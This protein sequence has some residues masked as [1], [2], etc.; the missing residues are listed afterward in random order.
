M[1]IPNEFQ[2][3]HNLCVYM[4]DVILD[5]LNSGYSNKM[6]MHKF[7]LTLDEVESLK[8]VEQ[9]DI[10][11][12]FEENN[13]P[14]ERSLTIRT[15]ILPHL[16]SDM[17]NFLYE[18]I[19][20]AE[21][22]KMSLAYTLLR[23][24][25]QEHL[26]LLEAMAV[27]EDFFVE[28][29]SEDPLY[30][31]PKNGGGVLGHTKRIH[32]IL[33]KNGL[34]HLIDCKYIAKLR[35]DKSDFDSFDR[36]CNQATHLF[37]EH[38][39]IKTEKQNINLIFSDDKDIY[40]QQRYFYTRMPYLL[41]YAYLV[42]EIVASKIAPAKENYINAINKKIAIQFLI[43]YSQMD[44]NYI[45]EPMV[46]VIKIFLLLLDIKISDPADVDSILHQLILMLDKD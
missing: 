41:Y 2:A 15:V 37:T 33:D 6:F 12:W 4:A 34:S 39:S 29:F 22:G 8:K 20:L 30:F 43:A 17:L 23:K 24:P 9:K 10:L 35:Y 44:G 40:T 46:R 38:K 32:K 21:Q 11:N 16:L 13:K 7:N 5:F 14:F 28:K 45:N 31:R 25:I 1:D 36:I 42:F 27:D 19:H 3:S 26:Y 18:S